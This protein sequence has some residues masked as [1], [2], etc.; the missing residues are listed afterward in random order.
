MAISATISD[1]NNTNVSL[2]DSNTTRVVSATVAGAQGPTGGTV[3]IDE[4]GRADA[5]VLFYDAS[6]SGGTG[7]YVA[8]STTASITGTFTID[9]GTF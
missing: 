2:S 1:S 9:G 8:S 5:S 4:S 6:A 7:A 3:P